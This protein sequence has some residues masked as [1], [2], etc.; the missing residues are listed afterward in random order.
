VIEGLCLL[1]C[2]VPSPADDHAS[3]A[4]IVRLDVRVSP[5]RFTVRDQTGREARKISG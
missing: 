5:D 3:S 4:S 2:G 1:D